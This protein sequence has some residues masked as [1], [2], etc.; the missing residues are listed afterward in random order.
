MASAS[1]LRVLDL[2]TGTGCISLALNA[3]LSAKFRD[4]QILGVDISP[5]A[6]RLAKANLRRN[7][8]L[9]RLPEKALRQ[10]RFSQKDI[11]SIDD[12]ELEVFADASNGCTQEQ[13]APERVQRDNDSEKRRWDILISNPPYISPTCYLRTTCRTVRNWEPRLALVPQ[14][15]SCRGSFPLDAGDGFYPCLLDL[16]RRVDT[17]IV[18][19]ETAD[20]AQAGRVARLGRGMSHW[21]GIE[22]WRDWPD[23]DDDGNGDG[24]TSV[25]DSGYDEKEEDNDSSSTSIPIRG[26]GNGRSV[27]L[28]K[29]RRSL[30]G[31]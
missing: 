22:I 25:E 20:L 17:G 29:R 2:C 24:K 12:S 1:P 28:W 8:I 19:L 15:K 30:R 7:V 10:V 6:N 4:L 14:Q 3:R 27:F 21:D 5:G 11:H 13:N 23:Q 26:T 9:G 16:A 31:R 18:L